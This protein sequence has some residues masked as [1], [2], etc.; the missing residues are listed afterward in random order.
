VRY[1]PGGGG[2]L[3]KFNHCKRYKI[4]LLQNILNKGVTVKILSTKDLQFSQWE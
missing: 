1:P 2:T 4:D 3:A